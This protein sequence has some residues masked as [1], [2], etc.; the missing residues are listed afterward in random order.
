MVLTCGIN[1][2]TWDPFSAQALWDSS[3]SYPFGTNADP[4]SLQKARV[5]MQ[6][7]TST[8]THGALYLAEGHLS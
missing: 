8:G 6:E 2:P 3:M 7:T 1:H 5:N 4:M